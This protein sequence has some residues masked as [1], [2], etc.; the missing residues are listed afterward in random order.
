MSAPKKKRSEMTS[1]ERYQRFIDRGGDPLDVD[2]G[3]CHDCGQFPAYKPRVMVANR[4]TAEVDKYYLD[5]PQICDE[6]SKKRGLTRYGIL[7]PKA[8]MQNMTQACETF[9][10]DQPE[11]VKKVQ[12]KSIKDLM[13]QGMTEED[14]KGMLGVK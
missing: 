6:C 10:V 5:L 12:A 9:L 1:Q 7:V 13:E 3:F 8:E 4:L 14:A 2:C 11:W